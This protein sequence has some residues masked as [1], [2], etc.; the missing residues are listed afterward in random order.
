MATKKAL[1][2]DV[3][4]N[5]DKAVDAIN[6]LTE[7]TK[8][9]EK[10]A[11]SSS[12]SIDK[13]TEEAART[14]EVP[15]DAAEKTAKRLRQA[16]RD[17]GVVSNA[18]A[19]RRRRKIVADFD[20]IKGSGTASAE[21]I[22]RAYARMQE[23]LDAVDASVGKHRITWK[24]LGS[25]AKSALGAIG[26]GIGKALG[27]VR[28]LS[29]AFAGMATATGYAIF[30]TAKS[31]A[32]YGDEIGKMAERSGVGV[33]AISALRL[34]AEQGDISFEQLGDGLKKFNLALAK[35]GMKREAV[36]AELRKDLAAAGGD[37][38][39]IAAAR[40]AADAAL[41]DP[42]RALSIKTRDARGKMRSTLDMLKDVADGIKAIPDP[43]RRLEMSSRFFGK[44]GGELFLTLLNQ[45]SK[46][47][48]FYE[49]EVKRLGI[50]VSGDMARQS[51][52]FNDS[53]DTM[54]KSWLGLKLAVGKQVL[55]QFTDLFASLTDTV[56][57]NRDSIAAALGS[58][59][60]KFVEI[61]RD[62][63]R[64]F[65]G[66]DAEVQNQWLIGIRDRL[67]EVVPTW[68]QMKAGVERLGP[69]LQ[70]LA[71]QLMDIAE[72]TGKVT[73][74]I[75]TLGHYLNK[76]NPVA[77][78]VTAGYTLAE[79]GHKLWNKLT[80]DSWDGTGWQGGT[81]SDQDPRLRALTMPS[82][83]AA[84]VGALKEYA[85]QTTVDGT[86]YDA[87][88]VIDVGGKSIVAGT[89][90]DGLKSFMRQ[91]SEAERRRITASINQWEKR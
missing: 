45:G 53:L 16:Y 79:G 49:A 85:F 26:S 11:V 47:I 54:G 88:L 87:K 5:T 48:A 4:A 57:A 30:R 84:N 38:D 46:G 64:L 68:D 90:A 14:V 13:L 77:L 76:I 10:A 91:L 72:W 2:V 29:L 7:N 24:S 65:Q 80:T 43:A 83:Q 66:K 1:T 33:E 71:G 82:P 17:M 15:A 52:E 22:K 63:V 35:S 81:L 19:E 51:Q 32:D 42:F 31:T 56:V 59:S 21:E 44:A 12:S 86:V 55:G 39:K 69:A 34:A 50:E 89:S 61:V 62:L 70:T 74:G 6:R 23:K 60:S 40:E 20:A 25:T 37:E 8:D 78:G 36:F 18:E 27:I 67:K 73:S 28:N 41:N 9:I 75:G 58:I 3:D